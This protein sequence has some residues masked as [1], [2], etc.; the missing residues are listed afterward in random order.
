MAILLAVPSVW[1]TA[2][3]KT[4]VEAYGEYRALSGIQDA[5][6]VDD[7]RKNYDRLKDRPEY[8]VHL[9]QSLTRTGTV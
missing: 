9:R 6:F 2:E 1:W 5:A 3:T 7:F 8:L 4:R